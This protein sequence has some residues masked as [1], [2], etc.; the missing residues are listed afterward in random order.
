MTLLIA[1]SQFE[2]IINENIPLSE[3][4]DMALN[5]IDYLYAELKS[6]QDM[7]YKLKSDIDWKLNNQK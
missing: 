1:K 4:F 3:R 6:Y 2:N 7:Y 5:E